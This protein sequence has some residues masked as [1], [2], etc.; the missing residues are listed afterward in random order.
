MVEKQTG[1]QIKHLQT[2][3]GLEFY[4]DEFNELCKSEGIVRHLIVRH[5]PQQNGIAE[6]MNRMIMEKVRC[7]LPNVNLP[8]SF[9]AEAISTACFSIADLYLLPMRKRLHKIY[10]LIQMVIFAMGEELESLHK[11]RTQDIAKLP[12]GKKVVRCKWVYKRKERTPKVE[13]LR[14]KAR[15][16]TKGYNQI[17]GV[18]FTDVFSLIMKQFDLSLAWYCGHL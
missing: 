14:Y 11:N 12:K 13:E 3:N 8:K 18:D 15:L 6:R 4:S 10:D 17:S 9:W 16:I 1:K 7:M 5:T 2:D